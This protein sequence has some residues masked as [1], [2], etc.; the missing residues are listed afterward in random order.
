MLD[1]FPF[2]LVSVSWCSMFLL[3]L[4]CSILISFCLCAHQPLGALSALV[5]SC[6]ISS[7]VI[8]NCFLLFPIECL[9]TFHPGSL[10]FHLCLTFYFGMFHLRVFKVKRKTS[11]FNEKIK[12]GSMLVT[13]AAQCV[14]HSTGA[15]VLG[16]VISKCLRKVSIPTDYNSELSS[17]DTP[18]AVLHNFS[19]ISHVLAIFNQF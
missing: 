15:G 12:A 1:N 18:L 8:C 19:A 7:N 10:L 4:L 17:G 5:F 6:I 9:K 11:F 13:C 3:Y 2:T 16:F 14:V